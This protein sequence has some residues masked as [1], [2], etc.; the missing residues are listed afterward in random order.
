MRSQLDFSDSLSQ[1][2]EYNTEADA[3]KRN[4]SKLLLI[5]RNGLQSLSLGSRWVLVKEMLLEKG[6]DMSQFA[7][8]HGDFFT[9]VGVHIET[10]DAAFNQ[11]GDTLRGFIGSSLIEAEGRRRGLNPLFV[12]AGLLL[13]ESVMTNYFLTPTQTMNNNHHVV[14]DTE[15]SRYICLKAICSTIKCACTCGYND[16]IDRR[17]KQTPS[18]FV[19][20][21]GQPTGTTCTF[22]VKDMQTGNLFVAKYSTSR[23]KESLQN[24]IRN[25]SG[26]YIFQ[27][28]DGTCK[29]VPCVLSSDEEEYDSTFETCEDEYGPR[30]LRIVRS[31]NAT[32]RI[33]DAQDNQELYRKIKDKLDR[34]RSQTAQK[35][36]TNSWGNI[37]GV[38]TNVD[39][40]I[41][42][43]VI[44]EA[45]ADY[46]RYHFNQT[47]IDSMLESEEFDWFA[48]YVAQDSSNLCRISRGLNADKGV[49]CR[50]HTCR[51]E[52]T[53]S[54]FDAA[55]VRRYFE[56][57]W[58]NYTSIFLRDLET[59]V[60]ALGNA[61][62]WTNFVQFLL[63]AFYYYMYARDVKKKQ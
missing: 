5:L 54:N 30:H 42:L 51:D 46:M 38:Q 58:D 25:N 59:Y 10:S 31:T 29:A 17:M 52:V 50:V 43:Q 21:H 24:I 48:E 57:Q 56:R 2:S 26:N 8:G 7:L 60:M 33:L 34:K 3:I 15:D 41:E 28:D 44:A 4:A 37:N 40:I 1:T 9:L 62:R 63:S 11:L 19:H 47:E 39:H 16:R 55:T 23:G 49:M 13:L 6:L 20:N 61:D 35:R 45:L 14:I 18:I 27:A 12:L 53:I 22:N 36:I 32:E